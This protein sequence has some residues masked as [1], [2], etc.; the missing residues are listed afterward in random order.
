MSRV[1][2]LLDVYY[3]RKYFIFII[4]LA[5]IHLTFLKNLFIFRLV[6]QLST[7][8]SIAITDEQLNNIYV[9]VRTKIQ[10]YALPPN[11]ESRKCQTCKKILLVFGRKKTLYEFYTRDSVCGRWIP[12]NWL[13]RSRHHYGIQMIIWRTVL[14]ARC[15]PLSSIKTINKDIGAKFKLK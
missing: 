12:H 10:V 5:I 2:E 13:F 11:Q 15:N 7:F 6:F 9:E 8:C 14:W 4:W 3:T 1:F